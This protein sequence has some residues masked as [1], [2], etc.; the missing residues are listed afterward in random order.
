MSKDINLR[1]TF[2]N[3]A[4][5]Y[6]RIRPRYPETLFKTLIQVTNLPKNAHLLEIGPGTGQAT[7][8]LAK[9]GHKITAIELGSDLAEVAKQVLKKYKDVEV[10]AGSFENYKLPAES[11]DLVYAATAFHWI[12]P[13]V[14]FLKSHK[15][16]K[17]TG[18]LAII[19]TEHVSD[20]VGDKFFF[21][22]QHLYRKYSSNFIEGFRLPKISELPKNSS[23]KSV[24]IDNK[25][26]E[27]T[28]FR[29]FPLVIHYSTVEY[30]QL[31]NTYSPVIALPSE[32]RE[33]FLEGIAKLIDQQFG[34]SVEKHYAMT[35]T[36][37]KKKPF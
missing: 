12:Q 5:L 27:T 9:L 6:H 26:F 7:E 8:P 14:K 16:L 33:K 13:K 4:Q 3:D 11:F 31:L 1:H 35:L 24:N 19:H 10:I 15:I 22:S 32:I 17:P 29:P 30:I 2:N 28:F 18:H 21:A 37:A 20:E 23:L 25:L 36:V 34:G